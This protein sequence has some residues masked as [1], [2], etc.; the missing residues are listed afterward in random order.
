MWEMMEEVLVENQDL[1]KLNHDELK[2]LFDKD[3]SIDDI[4]YYMRLANQLSSDDNGLRFLLSTCNKRDGFKLRATIFGISFKS[5]K[6]RE[7]TI[8]LLSSYLD[9]KRPLIIS[10][11]IDGLAEFK[12]DLIWEKIK[13]ML[14]HN[15]EYVRGAILRYARR[16]LSKKESF[17]ML[18]LALNDKHHIVRQNAIDELVEIG[19]KEAIKYINK[20]VKDKHPDVRL[21]AE[22]AIADLRYL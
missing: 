11:A 18:F 5:T 1:S 3:S 7:E 21:A 4:D 10:E 8:N 15:S 19:D 22:T 20:L 2:S 13:P 17:K 6:Y 9:D 16:V 14:N 12:E